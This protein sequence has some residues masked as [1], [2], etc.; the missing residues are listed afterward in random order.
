MIFQ[1]EVALV[2]GAGQ[3]IGESIA[4]LLAAEG[5]KVGVNALHEESAAKV[6][7]EIEDSG[8]KA[9][10]LPGDVA[11]QLIV[12]AIVGKLVKSFGPVDV[13]V[14]NAAALTEFKPFVNTT[15][16]DQEDDLTTL[17]GTFNC[18]RSVLP[19]MIDRRNGRIISI[20]ST[21]GY[22]ATPG[23]I[24]YCA[25]KAGINMFTKTLAREV[26]QY[27]I[28]VNVVSP[29]ATLTPRFKSRSSEI[30]DEVKRTIALRRFAEPTDIANAVLFLLK[31]EASYI[32]GTVLDVDGGFTGFRPLQTDG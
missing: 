25:A 4:K 18:T 22:Y 32:T 10:A 12:D 6:T 5:M 27:G 21:S 2:T 20:S 15:V 17:L 23:R 14:N 7:K 26:G 24:V 19:S 11:D 3:G 9:I 8:G 28:N 29:G 13:L 16:R 1:R 31:D 30:K